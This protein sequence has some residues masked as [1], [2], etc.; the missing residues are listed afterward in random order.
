VRHWFHAGARRQVTSEAPSVELVAADDLPR[1]LPAPQ[2]LPGA[3]AMPRDV[4]VLLDLTRAGI[5]TDLPER[6]AFAFGRHG[7][8]DPV[9]AAMDQVVRGS[10]PSR[11]ELRASGGRVLRRGWIRTTPGSLTSQLD[12]MLL[13][14][15][16]WPAQAAGSPGPEVLE[17]IPDAPRGHVPAGI[18]R[19]GVI[20]RHALTSAEA[21]LRHSEWTI[22]I[23]RRP[24]GASLGVDPPPPVSWLPHRPGHFAADPFGRQDGDRIHVLFEDFDQR[25]GRGSIGATTVDAS[26]TWSDPE[27]VLDTGSHASYPYLFDAEGATWMVPETSDLAQVQLYRALEFPRRWTLEATLLR[28]EQVSDATILSRDGRWWLFGT[29]RGRG[30]DEALRI[31]HAPSVTGPWSLHALDPVKIDA[32]SARP[33][34]TPFEVDG[35]LYRPAQDCSRR[36]GGRLTISRVDALDER[37]FAETPVRTLE[38]IAPYRDGLHTLSAAGA[39]TLVDGNRVRLVLEAARHRLAARLRGS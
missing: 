18:L 34:G 1:G 13:E 4:D 33:G 20:G 25:R 26:G 11:L 12:R 6:W 31:W 15:A 10:E 39:S 3:G 29:S 35:V 5:S 21:L 27:I 37:R 32:A 14:P 9:E 36:Y 24:I 7:L 22:G 17:P 19:L 8:A 28:D 23:A 2:P 30:V 16:A 38:P